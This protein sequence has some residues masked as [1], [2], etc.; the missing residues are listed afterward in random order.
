M[1]V[2]SCFLAGGSGDPAV[3]E[4]SE[5]DTEEV[6][7]YILARRSRGTFVCLHRIGGCWRAMSY[8]FKEYELIVTGVPKPDMYNSSCRDCWPR[9]KPKVDESE[10]EDESSGASTTSDASPE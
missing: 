7:G 10:D 9:G 4:A 8:A 2:L 1:F 3:A 6:A 5:T